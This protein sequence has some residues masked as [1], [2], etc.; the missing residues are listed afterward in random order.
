MALDNLIMISSLVAKC[1]LLNSCYRHVSQ[2]TSIIS[3]LTSGEAHTW[4]LPAVLSSTSFAYFRGHSF[5]SLVPRLPAPFTNKH[6][7]KNRVRFLMTDTHS[8]GIFDG[9]RNIRFV[10]PT[11]DKS[12]STR[13]QCAIRVQGLVERREWLTFLALKFVDTDKFQKRRIVYVAV[14]QPEPD[15]GDEL[16]QWPKESFLFKQRNTAIQVLSAQPDA[17]GAQNHVTRTLKVTE[18]RDYTG[19]LFNREVLDLSRYR[20]IVPPPPR[21]ARTWLAKPI[22]KWK[23]RKVHQDIRT[24]FLMR[25]KARNSLKTARKE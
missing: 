25:R 3:G 18:R 22:K 7:L 23:D 13:I 14:D 1:N 10:T 2:A 16:A 21:S 4:T 24:R 15:A 9:Q 5:A 11:Q 12:P 17:D 20:A 8:H 6:G 19:R